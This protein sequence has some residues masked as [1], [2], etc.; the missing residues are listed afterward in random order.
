VGPISLSH[1]LISVR[2][3][4]NVGR[5]A[6]Q[7]ILELLVEQA[8]R[9]SRQVVREVNGLSGLRNIFF[10][11]KRP[12]NLHFFAWLKFV[13]NMVFDIIACVDAGY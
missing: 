5:F 3:Q 9:S 7:E 10:H 4:R 2:F 1:L 12:K 13:F 11:I 8:A 6:N